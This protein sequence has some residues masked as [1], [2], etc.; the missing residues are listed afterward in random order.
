MTNLDGYSGLVSGTFYY[1]ACIERVTPEDA[2]SEN[3]C[4]QILEV[5]H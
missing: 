3:D 5:D 2:N 4:S 1:R